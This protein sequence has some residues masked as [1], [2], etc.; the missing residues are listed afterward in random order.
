MKVQEAMTRTIHTI[1]P[2]TPVT[3]AASLMQQMNIGALPV[4]KGS[5][6]VG[7]LT[8][9]DIAIRCVANCKDIS[10]CKAGDAMSSQIHKCR[11]DDDVEDAA[12]IMKTFKIRRLLVVDDDGNYVG[13]LSLGDIAANVDCEELCGEV[14]HEVAA[15][16][17][18]P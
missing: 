16:A 14:L 6:T 4:V 3:K 15:H 9:R 17:Y 13:I 2:Q 8:D 12:R 11:Q 1:S 10:K 5:E 18:S 7:I